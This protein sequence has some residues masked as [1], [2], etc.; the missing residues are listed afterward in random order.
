MFSGAEVDDGFRAELAGGILILGLGLELGFLM[1]AAPSAAA[2]LPFPDL[3]LDFSRGVIA[4]LD[5]ARS[6]SHLGEILEPLPP[7]FL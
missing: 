2:G 4:L 6:C 7:N 5:L 3:L 1:I